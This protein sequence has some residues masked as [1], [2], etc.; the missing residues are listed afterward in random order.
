MSLTYIIL[1]FES[2]R[3][4]SFS[5]NIFLFNQFASLLALSW[6]LR[7]ISLNLDLL[8]CRYMTDLQDFN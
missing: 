6:S 2:P 5:I 7:N 3:H 4:T 1:C 8:T